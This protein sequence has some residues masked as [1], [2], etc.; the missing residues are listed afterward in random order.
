MDSDVLILFWGSGV[1][2]ELLGSG[3]PGVL[4]HTG[5]SFILTSLAGSCFIDTCGSGWFWDDDRLHET[6]LLGDLSTMRSSSSRE[7]AALAGT[8]PSPGT[9]TPTK[10]FVRGTLCWQHWDRECSR[11]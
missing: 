1:V 9:S 3:D 5:N 6:L 7:M 2:R 10:A 11:F 8:C 4:L